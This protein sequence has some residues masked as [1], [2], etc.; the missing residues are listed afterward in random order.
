MPLYLRPANFPVDH[1]LAHLM[2]VAARESELNALRL[3]RILLRAIW[4]DQENLSD[5]ET[6]MRLAESSG[7]DGAD[8]VA[9]ARE[10]DIEAIYRQ[11]TEEA[12]ERQV[13]GAPTYV[14]GDA[15]FWGQDRLDFLDRHLAQAYAPPEVR[16]E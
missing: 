5:E 11:D 3:S 16:T 1:T 6:L 14:V 9:R 8:L 4:A 10:A 13:F 12:V 7:I 2:I 15:L